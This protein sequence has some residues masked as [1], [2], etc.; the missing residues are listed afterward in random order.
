MTS[1]FKINKHCSKKARIRSYQ[2]AN[3]KTNTIAKE[4]VPPLSPIVQP[5]I[6]VRIVNTRLLTGLINSLKSEMAYIH[7][8]KGLNT[9]QQESVY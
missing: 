7:V 9:E 2:N 4:G 1:P 6:L 5:I 8:N 3:C